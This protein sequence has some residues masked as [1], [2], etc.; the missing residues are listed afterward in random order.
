MT[1]LLKNISPTE[2]FIRE[3]RIYN[4]L[5]PLGWNPEIAAIIFTTGKG[6]QL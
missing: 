3:N 1:T 2:W 4:Q 5:R 6:I